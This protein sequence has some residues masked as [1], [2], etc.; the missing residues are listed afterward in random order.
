M[1]IPKQMRGCLPWAFRSSDIPE[2]FNSTGLGF[3][4]FS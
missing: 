3:K 1:F 2:R 4:S